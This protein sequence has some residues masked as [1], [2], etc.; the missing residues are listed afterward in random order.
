MDHHHELLHW[1]FNVRR[2]WQFLNTGPPFYLRLIRRTGWLWMY[3]SRTTDGRP[4]K[5]KKLSVPFLYP[6]VPAGLTPFRGLV[7]PGRRNL[8]PILP[9][10]H[11]LGG[12]WFL[13]N[14]ICSIYMVVYNFA[15]NY[16]AN[17][18]GIAILNHDGIINWR[19][20]YNLDL[21][22]KWKA[23]LHLFLWYYW[24]PLCTGQERGDF[25]KNKHE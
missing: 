3:T 6:G 22:I 7:P 4:F 16:K 21:K 15:L 1:V 5:P 2:G 9:P 14:N 19:L 20:G 8:V 13:W 10:A 23:K 18:H 24:V 11:L 17:G 25:W 12:G